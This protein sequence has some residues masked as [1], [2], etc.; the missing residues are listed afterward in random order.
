[1]DFRAL[2]ARR[3]L[4][5]ADLVLLVFLDIFL[6]VHL[7]VID[8]V[9]IQVLMLGLVGGL[10]GT[11]G[12]VVHIILGLGVVIV[13]VLMRIVLVQIYLIVLV[14]I[15]I[16]IVMF[17]LLSLSLILQRDSEGMRGNSPGT[18]EQ[19]Q[20]KATEQNNRRSAELHHR[21]ILLSCSE[22]TGDAGADSKFTT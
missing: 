17:A 11:Q 18:H 20:S 5:F 16:V 7:P 13:Q 12:L 10:S 6:Q 19:E 3:F 9:L 22:L 4:M 15:G 8:I 14:V 1:M 21:Y 2:Q